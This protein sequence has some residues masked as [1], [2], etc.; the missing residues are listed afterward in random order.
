MHN[1][2]IFTLSLTSVFLIG[3]SDKQTKSD[4]ADEKFI[5]YKQKTFNDLLKEHQEKEAKKNNS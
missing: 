2:L 1:F 3:C 5:D 4:K